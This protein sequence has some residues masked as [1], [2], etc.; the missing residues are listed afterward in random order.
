[1]RVTACE[2]DWGG[3]ED[4]EGGVTVEARATDR[5]WRCTAGRR[6]ALPDAHDAGAHAGVC[7]FRLPQILQVEDIPTQRVGAVAACVAPL[8]SH[9]P[10]IHQWMHHYTQLGVNRFHM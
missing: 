7:R 3:S 5:R 1:M 6:K 4:G 2:A 9:R 10:D 8:F